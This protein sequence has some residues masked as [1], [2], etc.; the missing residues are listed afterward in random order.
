MGPKRLSMSWSDRALRGLALSIR[1]ATDTA[2]IRR[3][4]TFTAFPPGRIGLALVAIPG[5]GV[6]VGICRRLSFIDYITMAYLI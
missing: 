6:V 5:L 4:P 3:V 1:Y 2:T